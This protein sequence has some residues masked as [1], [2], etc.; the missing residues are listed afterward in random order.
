M[1]NKIALIE[2][3]QNASTVSTWKHYSELRDV[4]CV[5]ELSNFC[6]RNGQIHADPVHCP[7]VENPKYICAIVL[8]DTDGN[9]EQS[10]SPALGITHHPEGGS[11]VCLTGF[12]LYSEDLQYYDDELDQCLNKLNP[13]KAAHELECCLDRLALL[14]DDKAG[15][16]FMDTSVTFRKPNIDLIESR[17][18]Y[19][20]AQCQKL[21]SCGRLNG[22]RYPLTIR[23]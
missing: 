18:A 9:V 6:T 20:H 11:L 15:V 3:P 12:C 21:K 14:K 10:Q 8:L 17:L 22:R 7:E 4:V 13:C 2:F 23:C 5:V 1:A 19:Y 16:N